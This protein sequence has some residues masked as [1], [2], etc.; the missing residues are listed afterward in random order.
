MRRPRPWYA[1]Q[2]LMGLAQRPL[3]TT[4]SISSALP[5]A[6][7]PI[8][9]A[10]QP[11][12]ATNA[13]ATPLP[14]RI[15]LANVTLALPVD[16]YLAL[17]TLMLGSAHVAP[18]TAG[19]AAGQ[20]ATLS[21][22][23]GDSVRARAAALAGDVR[24]AVLQVGLAPADALAAL[25]GAGYELSL[26]MGWGVNATNLQLAADKRAAGAAAALAVVAACLS[27]GGAV[28]AGASDG[29]GGGDGGGVSEGVLAGAVV[30]AAVGG[31]AVGALAAWGAWWLVARR[32]RRCVASLRHRNG[33]VSSSPSPSAPGRCAR[34]GHASPG[35]GF[36]MGVVAQEVERREPGQRRGHDHG[37]RR[38]GRAR[39]PLARPPARD[40]VT[41]QRCQ[42]EPAAAAGPRQEARRGEGPS[43]QAL[44][45]RPPP[46]RAVVA[47][48]LPA[49]CSLPTGSARLPLSLDG[50]VP[51]RPCSPD[52]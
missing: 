13:T 10:T 44:V 14:T 2:T 37:G 39:R 31:V 41:L 32:D 47:R 6:A 46:M 11:T 24:V 23:I 30:G 52:C 48:A 33:S 28:P 51:P 12:A 45:V 8:V 42:R 26:F 35:E 21:S 15:W 1:L 50:A 4:P 17:S 36:C 18:T 16:D 3:P 34:R 5:L 29:G 49:P 40:A 27:T 25:P 38:A 19:A 43:A 22:C 7:F 9:P 20:G